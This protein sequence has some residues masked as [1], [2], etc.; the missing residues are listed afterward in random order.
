MLLDLGQ[1]NI[2][3]AVEH[4]VYENRFSHQIMLDCSG[5]GRILGQGKGEKTH[6]VENYSAELV[7]EQMQGAKKT[8]K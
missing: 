8:P 7:I 6:L 5:A 4:R 2:R 3:R 1:F